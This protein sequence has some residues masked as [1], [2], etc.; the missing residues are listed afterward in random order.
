MEAQIDLNPARLN[1]ASPAAQVFFALLGRLHCGSLTLQMPDG[2]RHSFSGAQPG[3]AAELLVRRPRFF[4]RLVGGGAMG[5]A[6]AYMDGDCTTP[7]L[8]SLVELAAFNEDHLG[9]AL[10][11]QGWLRALKRIAHLVRPNSK[12]GSRRNIAFHYDLGNA[13]YGL[14]LGPSMT[15]SSAV[16]ENAEQD[17]ESAQINKFRH[18]A[19][20]ANIR[21]GQHL[22][23]IG[24]GWG[25]FACWAAREIDCRVTA[26]TISQ[27]QHD[28][29]AARVRDAG[30]AGKVE[31]RLQDYRDITGQYDGIVSIEML[32]AVG[33]GYWPVYFERLR[34]ALKPGGRAALQVI[35]I[36]DRYFETYRRNADFIQSYIF[37]GGLLPSPQVLRREA[38][39]AGLKIHAEE[40]YGLDYARTLA[41]WRGRFEEAWPRIAPLGFDERFHQLWR[42]YLAY[43]EAGFRVGR[44][45]LQQV[46][47]G[48]D[49]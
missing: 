23:E 40:A 30:L 26:I 20:L 25:E 41:I 27:A 15:Y 3:P 32:E 2:R 5:F 21:P 44:I 35:T 13:F 7:D 29:A 33:E 34:R 45:D 6:E 8:S 18:M 19:R 36:A 12:S 24:C 46:A 9:S 48:R 38:E 39:D 16:F 28:F 10:D 14:W 43:C 47:V 1:F 49:R 22:L 31:V 17:L 42:Y 37:P 4:R 11:G